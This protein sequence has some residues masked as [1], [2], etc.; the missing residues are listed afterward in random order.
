MADTNQNPIYIVGTVS[1]PALQVS[2]ICMRL[3]KP[4]RTEVSKG[5]NSEF[6]V[7]AVL[8]KLSDSELAA[9]SGCRRVSGLLDRL[10]SPKWRCR[11]G[12]ANRRKSINDTRAQPAYVST[13]LT[14]LWEFRN[15]FEFR[16]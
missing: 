10:P 11:L 4:V 7:G 6:G 5:G 9:A 12:D 1:N 3:P 2:A 8:A 15:T 13:A 16:I 14:Q